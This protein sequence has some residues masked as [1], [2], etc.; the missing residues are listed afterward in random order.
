MKTVYC[1]ISFSFENKVASLIKE[2][3]DKAK[4]LIN[5]KKWP[6]PTHD[7]TEVKR[8]EDSK[9]KNTFLIRINKEREDNNIYHMIKI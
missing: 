4:W 6:G 2:E 5:L 9:K 1:S 3:A 7:V 8:Q